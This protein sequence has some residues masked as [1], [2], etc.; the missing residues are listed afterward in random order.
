MPPTLKK[1]RRRHDHAL[2]RPGPNTVGGFFAERRHFAAGM[3]VAKR[4]NS[5]SVIA[6]SMTLMTWGPAPPCH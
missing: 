4:T 5:L 3:Q 6:Y 1:E 2:R